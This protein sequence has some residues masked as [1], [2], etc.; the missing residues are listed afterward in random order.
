MAEDEVAEELPPED[1]AKL[2]AELEELEKLMGHPEIQSLATL[3]LVN[4]RMYF[5]L[6]QSVMRVVKGV[7]GEM[8]EEAMQHYMS[9][10]AEKANGAFSVTE[11][12]SDIKK[13]MIPW[14]RQESIR[15]G[16]E[17]SDKLKRKT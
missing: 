15:Q 11:L 14:L 12:R 3:F 17:N 8:T 1:E 7:G 16:K 5:L 10:L 9:A 13:L 4:W 6:R 2:K